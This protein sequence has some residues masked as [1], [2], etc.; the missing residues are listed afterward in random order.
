MRKRLR[1]E[2]GNALIESAIT[3]PIILLIAVGIFE[4]GRAYQTQQVLTNAAREGARQAVLEGVTDATVT[5]VVRTY[6]TNGGLTAV[7]PVI[8]HMVSLNPAVGGCPCGSQVTINYPFSFIVL[9]PVAKLVAP[10][11]K[12]KG[13][14]PMQASALMRNE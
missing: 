14:I 6:L 9:Q 4:F 5:G 12:M 10:N 7:D 11:S 13:A 3:V 8:D 1:S 2:R